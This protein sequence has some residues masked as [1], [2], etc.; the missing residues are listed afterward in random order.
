MTFLEAARQ[1]EFW[2]YVWTVGA[3]CA[4]CLVTAVCCGVVLSRAH[5]RAA[6]LDRIAAEA[7]GQYR[8]D[9]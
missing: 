2:R 9:T 1:P 5:R 6:A 3:A 8:R 4:V 7:R